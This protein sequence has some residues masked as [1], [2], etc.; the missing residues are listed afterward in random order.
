MSDAPKVPGNSA[1]PG[2]DSQ[3]PETP[4]RVMRLAR[5]IANG[6]LLCSLFLVTLLL[7]GLILDHQDRVRS[8]GGFSYYYGLPLAA[9]AFLVTILRLPDDRKVNVTMGLI[10]IAC[11][12]YGFEAWL[13]LNRETLESAARSAGVP[14]DSRSRAE[15]IRDLEDRGIEAVPW[16]APIHFLVFAQNAS[17]L[18]LGR[19]ILPLSRRGS[20]K[21]SI[22]FRRRWWTNSFAG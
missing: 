21:V 2:D 7:L 14:F 19:P 20:S 10:A 4:Q 8:V 6:I 3:P 15:V 9:L 18:V 16:S 12:V 13:R 5:A 17:A 1:V 11:T 22:R